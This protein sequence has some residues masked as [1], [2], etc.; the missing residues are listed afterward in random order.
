MKYVLKT[1]L[2]FAFALGLAACGGGGGDSSAPTNNNVP[3][4]VNAGAN[5]SSNEQQEVTLTAQGFPAGG[6]YLWTQTAGPLVSGLPIS[7]AEA[8]FTLPA[9][10]TEQT[11]TMQAQYTTT[12]GDVVTDTVDIA[13]A[14]VNQAPVAVAQLT[15]PATSPVPPEVTVV[16]S[17]SGSTDSD[18]SI[19]SYTWQQISGSPSVVPTG[20]FSSQEFRFVAPTIPTSLVFRLMVTDDENATSTFDVTVQVD[21]NLAAVT[22]DAGADQFVNE[23]TSATISATG[24]P[25]GGTYFW[26]QQT[27][28]ALSEFPS[29]S[30]NVSFTLPSTKLAESYDFRVEYQAPSGQIAHDLVTVNVNPVNKLP[31]SLIRI[32]APDVLPAQPS[33]IVTLDGSGSHDPDTDGRIESYTWSQISGPENVVREPIA[34][35]DLFS[36]RTPVRETDQSYTFRLVVTDDEGGQG[37]FDMAVNVLGTTEVIKARAGAD[38]T[39]NE[40]K[41]VDLDGR[42]SYSIISDVTCSWRQVSGPTISIAGANTCQPRFIAPNVDVATDVILELMASNTRND[43]ATDTV[44]VTVKP[45]NFGQLNDTG[46]TNC[47]NQTN[48]ISCNDSSFPGQDGETG[49]DA[50]AIHLDKVGVGQASF[51]FTKLDANGDE[52][53]NTA[54]TFAC[55]RD[56]N[57]GLIWELKT[58]SSNL[59]PN[60]T[61]RDANNRYTWHYPDGSIGGSEGVSGPARSTCPSTT[62]CGLSVY[63]EEVNATLYCGGSNWRVPTARE[64]QSIINYQQGTAVGVLDVSLFDDLPSSSLIGS[65]YY[66]TSQ[67][68][69]DGGGEGSAWV[70]DFVNGNDN[71]VPKADAVFVRL[72]RNP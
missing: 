13:V 40:F 31:V 51:D 27:G 52:L 54:A 17:G 4:S 62:D 49:T 44:K 46:A 55:V 71:A 19:T 23:Q 3:A 16:L 72:V 45:L 67:T 6:S 26:V 18:G 68:S 47:Y 12:A 7:T 24:T 10:K 50:V 8:V 34:S 20:G 60:T 58:T 65:L 41:T 35:P 70:I 5:V 30:Q 11:I 59:P 21:P 42:E 32:I 39:V 38:Q 25:S 64:L 22:V 29:S 66:Y 63:V 43:T 37:T 36:F 56:N 53:P 14:P 28:S 61:L 9:V 48:P 33:E 57:T 69:A 2:A 1:G 15:N